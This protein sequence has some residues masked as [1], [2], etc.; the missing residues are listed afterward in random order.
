MLSHLYPVIYFLICIN[1]DKNNYIFM[2]KKNIST[3]F[4]VI[5]AGI[6][7]VLGYAIY[8]KGVTF[9]S[10]P[11]G[12]GTE[13]KTPPP[14]MR[15]SDDVFVFPAPNAPQEDRDRH[16]AS[17]EALAKE[18][19]VLD[20]TDCKVNPLVLKTGYGKSITV[21]NSG[22]SAVEIQYAKTKILAL[23]PKAKKEVVLSEFLGLA[24]SVSGGFWIAGYTCNHQPN[25][26]GIFYLTA[27]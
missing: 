9:P 22:A 26:S 19:D 12:P 27:E 7:I 21:K 25:L 14:S 23:E 15:G 11:I 24:P 10:F 2:E 13:T 6:A 1:K 5:L 18:S 8:K 20:A 4:V 16:R 3:F 17:V